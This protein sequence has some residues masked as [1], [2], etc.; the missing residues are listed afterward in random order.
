MI[1][2]LSVERLCFF[3]LLATVNDASV[4][5]GY[6]Y[7]FQFLVLNILGVF[8]GLKLM[9]SMLTVFVFEE[10]PT[11][12]CSC[13]SILLYGIY[14]CMPLY[15]RVMHLMDESTLFCLLI[16]LLV[17]IFIVFTLGC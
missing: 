4:N 10:P 7:L 16:N 17:D 8:P 11:V 14:Y 12:F 15:G 6:K 2:H 5:M 1:I 13:G 3:H 9:G